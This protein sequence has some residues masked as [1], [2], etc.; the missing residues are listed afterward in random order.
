MTLKE[1]SQGQNIVG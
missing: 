1:V